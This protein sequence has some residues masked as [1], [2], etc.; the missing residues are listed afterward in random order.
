MSNP[1]GKSKPQSVDE[2]VVTM[3]KAKSDQLSKHRGQSTYRQA[4]SEHSQSEIRKMVSRSLADMVDYGSKEAVR[5]EDTDTIRERTILYL[6]CCQETATVPSMI[7]LCRSLG[8]T[9][10]A[11]RYWRSKHANHPTALW[12][13][14]FAEMCAECLSQAALQG[15]IQPIVGIFILKSCHGWRETSEVVLSPGA[16]G[17]GME[18]KEYDPEEIRRRY[19]IDVPTEESENE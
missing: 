12:L 2:M 4:N 8:Y 10:R 17:A 16:A 19:L 5:M 15:N 1:G 7:G 6:K 13:E 14:S 18:E 9:D 11:A 3:T